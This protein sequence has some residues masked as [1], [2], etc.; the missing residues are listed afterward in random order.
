MKNN[1]LIIIAISFFLFVSFVFLSAIERKQSDINRAETWMVYFENPKDNSFDFKIE[2]RSSETDF[3]WEIFSD[4]DRLKEGDAKISTG[5]IKKIPA[6][7]SDFKNKK[8]TIF[9]TAG[10]KKKEIYKIL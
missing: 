9:V 5:E 7:I 2:N 4:K 6:N 10:E 1:K 8:I 3:H